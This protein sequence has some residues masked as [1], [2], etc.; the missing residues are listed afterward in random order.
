MVDHGLMKRSLTQP[1]LSGMKSDARWQAWVAKGRAHDDR[2]RY[3]VR[4][5]VLAITS[6]IAIGLAVLLTVR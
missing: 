4:Q 5:M 1:S 3:R 2:V 6:L